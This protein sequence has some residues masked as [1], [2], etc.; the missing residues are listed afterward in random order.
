MN[1]AIAGVNDLPNGAV[2]ISGTAKQGETLTAVTSTISD[3]DGLGDFSYQWLRDGT[4][5]SG[6]TA[7]TYTLAQAD[8]GAAISI[9]ASY[10]D[11]GGTAESVTSAAKLAV[12]HTVG[13]SLVNQALND[14]E[15]SFVS[16]QGET[17]VK[18]IIDH[19]LDYTGVSEFSHVT[20]HSDTYMADINISDVIV[21][22][23]HIVGLD[24]LNGAG[25]EAADVDNNGD[26]SI[27]DVISQLRHIVGLE[28]ITRFDLLDDVGAR[29]TNMD[30]VDTDLQLI[31]NGDV[32][33]STTL[34]SEHIY[35]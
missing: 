30:N 4:D 20:L 33:L 34:T 19:A 32:D 1:V 9:Q 24:T 12:T 27:G 6:A 10:T 18:T 31:L 2:T 11:G 21:S 3:A 29:I 25:L 16:K 5:I 28:T 14:V 23:R 22:L 26:I 8:V 15:F 35:V 7:S 17:T 13:V